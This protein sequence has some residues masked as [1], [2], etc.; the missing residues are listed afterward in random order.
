MPPPP[1]PQANDDVPTAL[2]WLEHGR[3]LQLL[4]AYEAVRSGSQPPL[5]PSAASEAPASNDSQIHWHYTSCNASIDPTLG[6]HH[7]CTTAQEPE[8]AQQR[9]TT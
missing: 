4:R 1:V 9:D 6:Q 3:G 5:P 8:K 2:A 7:T